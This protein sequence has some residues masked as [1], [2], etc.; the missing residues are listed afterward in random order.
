METKGEG[1]NLSPTEKN[2][3]SVL[4]DFAMT[5]KTLH[6]LHLYNFNFINRVPLK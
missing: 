3:V 5:S 6:L 2:V 1:S 4:M